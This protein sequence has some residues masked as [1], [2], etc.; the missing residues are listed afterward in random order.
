[1]QEFYLF[2]SLK[3]NTTKSEAGW[4]GRSKL[5]VSSTRQSQMAELIIHELE[6]SPH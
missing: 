1:M 6:R 2:S 5:N 4:M 3:I